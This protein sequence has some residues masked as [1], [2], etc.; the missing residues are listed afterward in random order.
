MSVRALIKNSG[1]AAGVA[2]LALIATACGG[3]TNSKSSG[4]PTGKPGTPVAGDTLTVAIQSPPNS[5]NPGTVDNAFTSYTLLAYDPLIYQAADGSLQP[6]LATSW[7]YVGTGNTQLDLVL[8]PNVTFSDGGALTAA[9][10]KASLDYARKAPGPQAQLLGDVKSI[11]VT[12]P[13][14][15][16]IKLSASNPMLPQ[17]LTQYYGIGQIISPKALAD[18]TK[19]T[20][21]AKSA[22]AGPYVLDP[23]ASV[24]GDHYAYTARPGYFEPSRQHYK[25]IVMRVI[26]NPQAVV[27]A[28][29]TGQVDIMAGGDPATASQIKSASL[30]VVSMPFVWNGLN[31]IDR[32]GEVSKPLGDVRVR[33]AINYALDRPTVSKAVLGGYG[34]PTVQTVVQGADGYSADTAKQYAYDPDKAKQLLADAGYPNGFTLSVLSIAFGGIDTMG[35]AIKGQLAKVGITVKLATVTDAQT[36]A[37]DMVNKKY[38]A[39][40]VGYGASPMYLMGQGLF[41]PT[42]AVFNGFKTNSPELVALYNQA[43]AAGPDQRATLDQQ[44]QK[45]LVDNAWFAPVA[46]SPVLYFARPDLGGVTVSAAAPVACPLDWYDTK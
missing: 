10:V 5:L 13:L 12:G 34:V 39:V 32:G 40:S 1:W 38:P 15:L 22:G 9:G 26:A 44:M 21:A 11:D 14:A 20:V 8:R 27:N 18:P 19:L 23:A 2:V 28:L 43:A 30:Q 31:L 45:Y 46:F 3:G 17:E 37:T 24:A 16:S 41:L 35:Q 42:A 36:Y 4:N 6:D 29:K 33:Q 7:K 25:K